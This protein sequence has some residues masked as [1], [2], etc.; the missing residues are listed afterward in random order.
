MNNKLS[1]T[2]FT[3]SI[4]GMMEYSKGMQYTNEKEYKQLLRILSKVI[5][6][7]LTERQQQCIVMR[8]YKNLTVTEIANQLGIGKS[9]ASRHIKKAKTRLYKILDYYILSK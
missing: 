7:E 4:A 5:V 8:Y 2:E 1:L 3:E 9:T 6:G